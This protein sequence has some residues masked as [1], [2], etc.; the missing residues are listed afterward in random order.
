MPEELPIETRMLNAI[1]DPIKLRELAIEAI[2]EIK[3]IRI[4]GEAAIECVW[5]ANDYLRGDELEIHKF[6]KSFKKAFE[7]HE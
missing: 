6:E 1:N 4:K 7:L 2:E 3:L 5:D